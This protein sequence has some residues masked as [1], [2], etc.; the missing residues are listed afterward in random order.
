M[1]R[2]RSFIAG[3]VA[4]VALVVPVAWHE[5]DAT[6]EKDGKKLRPLEQSVVIDGAKVTL[7]VD[8]SLVTTGDTVHA[9]LRAFG[10]AKQVKVDL[11]LYQSNNYAGERVERPQ[12]PI[13]HE[14]ITL[15]A[16]PE[17]GKPFVTALRLGKQQRV[18]G[19]TDT[20]RIFV[21]AHGH[22]ATKDDGG[23]YDLTAD[24]GSA[25]AVSIR[26]WSG[27]SLAMTV[28]PEGKPVAGEPFTVVVKVR[29]TTGRRLPE[30]PI[31]MLGTALDDSGSIVSGDDFD[32]EPSDEQPVGPTPTDDGKVTVAHFL[33]TPKHAVTSVTFVV[34]ATAYPGDIGPN[35]GGAID[36]KTIAL[37]EAEVARR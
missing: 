8:R 5:L 35:L 11:T 23:T 6:I 25:A 28:K 13:D 18:A 12:V 2:D 17:G 36:I 26:G 15:E 3:F 4:T 32:I 34:E 29:N 10:A 22:H 1:L 14:T 19:R 9:T 20:F 30:R 21:A 16:A 7:D 27:N 24:D 37:G 31:V 33:V